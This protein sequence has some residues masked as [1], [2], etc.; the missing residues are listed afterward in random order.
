MSKQP[1]KCYKSNNSFDKVDYCFNIVAVFGNKVKRVFRLFDKVQT[2]WTCSICFDKVERTN[3]KFLLKK[4]VWT[5]LQS[6]AV[7]FMS[8]SFTDLK[9]L[10]VASAL[11]CD[12][13]ADKLQQVLVIGII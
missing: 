5:T 1:V 11:V 7:S 4:P 13:L 10:P 12:V 9:C 6:V 3:N 2:N 8:C